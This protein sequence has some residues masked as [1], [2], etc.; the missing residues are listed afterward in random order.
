MVEAKSEAIVRARKSA[1]AHSYS[2][3]K[4]RILLALISVIVSKQPHRGDFMSRIRILPD[5]KSNNYLIVLDGVWN[6]WGF[7]AAAMILPTL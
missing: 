1:H 5:G 3:I 7:Q 4:I 6:S 2:N